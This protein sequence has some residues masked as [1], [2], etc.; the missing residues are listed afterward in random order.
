MGKL[1]G[2]WTKG[3]R[4]NCVWRTNFG[5]LNAPECQGVT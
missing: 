5:P 4:R 3:L 1:S 2:L